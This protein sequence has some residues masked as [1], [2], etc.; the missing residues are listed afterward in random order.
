M[1]Q[2]K[3]FNHGKRNALRKK[4]RIKGI[5]KTNIGSGDD[6][7]GESAEKV[8]LAMRRSNLSEEIKDQ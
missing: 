3:Q 6:T 7:E 2:L 4:S 5:S 1:G 8:F